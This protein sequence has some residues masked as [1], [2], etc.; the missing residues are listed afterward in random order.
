MNLSIP[1]KVWFSGSLVG[2]WSSTGWASVVWII[3]WWSVG[4]E[5]MWSTAVPRVVTW[6]AVVCGWSVVWLVRHVMVGS[7]T[8]ASLCWM[9]FPWAASIVVVPI[10]LLQSGAAFIQAT[11]VWAVMSAIP[12]LWSGPASPFLIFLVVSRAWP[13]VAVSVQLVVL[14][15]CAWSWYFVSAVH[16]Y[17]SIFF[18]F[19][20]SH[21]RAVLCDMSWFLAWK[22]QSSLFDI[23]LTLRMEGCLW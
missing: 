7:A 12:R 16:D 15:W 3:F 2:L 1:T 23:M 18:A 13:G 6:W 17:M 21:M 11:M 9:G 8:V 20:T 10:P 4:W 22:H 14:C 5:L 19:M